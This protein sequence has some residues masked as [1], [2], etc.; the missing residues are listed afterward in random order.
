MQISFHTE[1]LNSREATGI[2]SFLV[3]LYGQEIIPASYERIGDLVVASGPVASDLVKADFADLEKRVAAS[4]MTLAPDGYPT[5]FQPAPTSAPVA[6]TAE[7]VIAG[8]GVLDSAGIPWDERIHASTK[9]QNK[10][11]TWTRRR[12][13]ED[14]VFDAVMAELKGTP[15]TVKSYIELPADA[16]STQ[17]A[18]AFAGQRA[19]QA[20]SPAT[21]P[22]PPAPPAAPAAP[23]APPVTAPAGGAAPTFV[24]IMTKVTQLQGQGK[25]PKEALEANVAALGLTSISQLAPVTAADQRVAFAAMLDAVV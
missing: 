1:E 15:L 24:E 22:T 10:D 23:P 7:V 14:A 11:G 2:V 4:G 17:V 19:A 8:D 12:N 16:T 20:L 9:T 25:L 13:T 3:A 6:P 21:A 5:Q 18:E